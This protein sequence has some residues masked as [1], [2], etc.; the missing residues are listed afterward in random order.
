MED[1]K[2]LFH[3][4]IIHLSKLQGKLSW[5]NLS[6]FLKLE[7]QWEL[8]DFLQKLLKGQHSRLVGK[9]T[10]HNPHWEESSSSPLLKFQVFESQV[11]STVLT[12]SHKLEVKQT[13][14]QTTLRICDF[15]EIC[16]SSK[17]HSQGPYSLK[18]V[19]GSIISEFLTF[20]NEYFASV[21]IPGNAR[22]SLSNEI[23]LKWFTALPLFLGAGRIN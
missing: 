6:E 5:Q 17:S 2:K 7:D 15:E 19:L 14:G 22:L 8:W 9:Y 3:K 16:V 4:Y 23:A 11:W 1:G 20:N 18:V 12:E 21:A 10:D 13:Q